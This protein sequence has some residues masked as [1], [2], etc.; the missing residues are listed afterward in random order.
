MKNYHILIPLPHLNGKLHLYIFFIFILDKPE[1]DSLQIEEEMLLVEELLTSRMEVSG[2]LKNFA[3]KV[4]CLPG[5]LWLLAVIRLRTLSSS[6]EEIIFLQSGGSDCSG[7][8]CST[9]PPI[10]TE[11][12]TITLIVLSSPHNQHQ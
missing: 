8:F 6:G 11:L 4:E 3:R 5:G 9:E 2:D 1:L 10:A 7:G 12:S